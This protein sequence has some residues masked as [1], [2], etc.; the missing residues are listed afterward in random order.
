MIC[1]VDPAK[2]VDRLGARPLPIEVLPFARS[3]VI[4]AIEALGAAPCASM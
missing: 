3:F 1:I 2:L 4:S